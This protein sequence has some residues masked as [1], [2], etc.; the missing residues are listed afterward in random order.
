M[1]DKTLIPTNFVATVYGQLVPLNN[2]SF[3]KARCRI[4]YKGLNRNGSYISDEVADQM[5]T[6]LP[7][8]PV[9]GNF[10][11]DKDDF[12]GHN[13]DKEHS[14]PYGFVP[15]DMNFKWEMFLDPDG[16]YRTYACTDLILWTGRYPVAS[17]IV[18]KSHS[19]ELNP[20]TTEGEWVE[21]N[22]DYYFK[23]SKAEF[24]GLCVLG[25]EVEPCFEGSCF[26]S[27]INQ[28]NN[29]ELLKKELKQLFDSY[30]TSED[31]T[32]KN[33]TGGQEM[34]KKDLEPQDAVEEVVSNSEEIQSN[35]NSN[36]NANVEQEVID[37][38]DKEIIEEEAKTEENQ[39][40]VEPQEENNDNKENENNEEEAIESTTNEEEQ[41]DNVVEETVETVEETEDTAE[42]QI[43][44]L[45]SQLSE[46]DNKIAALTEE[47]NSLKEY[48]AQKV[49]EEK[50]NV[51]N[52]YS[53][54]LSE[55]ELSNFKERID[56]YENAIELK[57]DIA[58]ALLDKETQ[59]NNEEIDASQFTLANKSQLSGAGLI[60]ANYIKT[61]K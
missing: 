8:T 17:K 54:K 38:N 33:L 24:F 47:L 53:N 26:Y 46:K 57:K 23:I 25:D 9:I 39:E 32:R 51:L 42:Q 43:E 13:W 44:I 18:G 27:R 35:E 28:A 4:F 30:S 58:L 15:E 16:V 2:S 5:I 37:N 7:G 50:E 40:I 59:E 14:V 34:N 56:S 11:G 19:M 12:L 21:E 41:N 6:T 36:E 61:R 60:V 49:H 45:N 1:K 31:S 29:F 55:E 22:G 52:T 3:S 20:D 10:D 48:K